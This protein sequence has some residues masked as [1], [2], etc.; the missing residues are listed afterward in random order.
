MGSSNL[1]SP[2]GQE[3]GHRLTEL[4]AVTRDTNGC[5]VNSVTIEERGARPISGSAKQSTE[6]L[7]RAQVRP[8]TIVIVLK[9]LCVESSLTS[10]FSVTFSTVLP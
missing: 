2:V 4:P 8:V 5:L 7:R 9:N 1:S 3:H 6:K 10:L